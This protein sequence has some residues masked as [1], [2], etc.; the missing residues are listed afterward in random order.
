M[1]T[2]HILIFFL[3]LRALLWL[4]H[5]YP[6]S[7]V[8]RVAFSWIGP[9]PIEQELFAHF[10]LR[11]AIFSFGWLCHFAIAIAFFFMIGTH[12]PNQAEQIWFNVV[13]F[14]APLGLG[15][16]VLATVGFLI[17]AGKAYW[18]GPN[19]RFCDDTQSDRA[20]E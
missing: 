11:W 8:S 12:F 4:L 15:V 16:A 6:Q 7:I 5:R 14:A 20:N 10:Q 2:E 13:L 17:K 19:P 9:L 18:F 3:F 1:K